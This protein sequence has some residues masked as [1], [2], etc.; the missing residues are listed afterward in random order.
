[1]PRA[2][3]CETNEARSEAYARR[4]WGE[5]SRSQTHGRRAAT[6]PFISSL[7]TG[8]SRERNATT[9]SSVVKSWAAATSRSSLT[10]VGIRVE[11]MNRYYY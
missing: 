4:L 10:A 7:V 5:G 8:N 1:M 2:L 11:S 6:G 9:F 3:M